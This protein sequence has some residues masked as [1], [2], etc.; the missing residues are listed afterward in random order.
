MA[1]THFPYHP[2]VFVWVF[3]FLLST[4]PLKTH[5]NWRC[6]LCLLPLLQYFLFFSLNS[7]RPIFSEIDL[8]FLQST[9]IG[10]HAS[11][12]AFIN[13]SGLMQGKRWG[14][15]MKYGF[16]SWYI[17][18]MHGS[19]QERPW[20]HILNEQRNNGEKSAYGK[21]K[22]QWWRMYRDKAGVIC[23]VPL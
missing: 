20:T 14:C 15:S 4:L 8:F 10:G 12:P 19:R 21:N 9:N 1:E 22:G 5:L 6:C 13:S 2:G 16:D 3:F 23:R 18:V 17:R 11:L 7:R